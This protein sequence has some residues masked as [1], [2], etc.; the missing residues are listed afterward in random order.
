MRTNAPGGRRLKLLRDAIGAESALERSDD[1]A[2]RRLVV[3]HGLKLAEYG[4]F[5]RLWSAGGG[6]L[7]FQDA[8]GFYRGSDARMTAG[9][10]A[11]CRKNYKLCSVSL[12]AEKR[13]VYRRKCN[14][15]KVVDCHGPWIRTGEYQRAGPERPSS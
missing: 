13:E 2:R 4:K 1:R 14:A 8:P 3:D 12:D 5:G 10:K 9:P 15:A 11:V 6:G 7:R